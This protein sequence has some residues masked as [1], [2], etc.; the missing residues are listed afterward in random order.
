M[1]PKELRSF[2][3]AIE[4][5]GDLVATDKEVDWDLDVCALERLS[6]E[7]GGPSILF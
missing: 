2:L 7:R 4:K 5:S 1:A 6:R 3:A